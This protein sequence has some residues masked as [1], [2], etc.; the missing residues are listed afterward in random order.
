MIYLASPYSDPD[1]Q[2]MEE[3]YQRTFR[4]TT[5]QLLNHVPIFSPIVYGYPFHATGALSG[6]ADT[7]KFLNVAMVNAAHQ[8]HVLTLP[9]WN[10]SKGV[11]IEIDLAHR[12]NIPVSYVK[13]LD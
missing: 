1:P 7:W 3:R 5:I 4:Y 6:D 12:L 10:T 2:V 13:P 9:G 8:V 11:S